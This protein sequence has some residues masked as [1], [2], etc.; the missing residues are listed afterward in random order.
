MKTTINPTKQ[1]V[2]VIAWFF[3]S[4][5]INPKITSATGNAKPIVIAIQEPQLEAKALPPLNLSSGDH[6]CPIIGEIA[7]V[8]IRKWSPTL[9]EYSR[10]PKANQTGIADL[11]TS[12]AI[13]GTPTRH[14]AIIQALVAP[15]LPSPILRASLPEIVLVKINDHGTEPLTNPTVIQ[16]P[17]SVSVTIFPQLNSSTNFEILG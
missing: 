11:P 8:A 5:C 13:D 12:N 17:T 15:G 9:F 3:W 1:T 16:M 10:D 7:I 14:P 4:R 2:T 6:A